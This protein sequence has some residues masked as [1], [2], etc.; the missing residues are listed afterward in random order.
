MSLWVCE[1]GQAGPGRAAVLEK[2]GRMAAD[3]EGREVSQAGREGAGGG[4]G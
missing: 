2:G 3:K 4:A 1:W